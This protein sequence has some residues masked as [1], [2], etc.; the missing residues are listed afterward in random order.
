ME[1]N[2]IREHIRLKELIA[3][4][5]K[6]KKFLLYFTGIFT[7]LIFIYSLICPREYE[8]Y[9]SIMPPEKSNTPG[10]SSMLSS[11]A[12]GAL[13]LANIDQSAK[14]VLYTEMLKSRQVASYIAEKLNLKEHRLFKKM[15]RDDMLYEILSLMDVSNNRSGIIYVNV[16]VKTP[17]F[18]NK[19]EKDETAKLASDIAN[20]AYIALDSINRSISSTKAF[21]KKEFIERV[22]LEK[23]LE[24]DSIDRELE[25][26]Q[27]ENKVLAI[28]KQT[29]AIVTNAIT[30]G[31]EL[32]K[33]EIEL[34]IMLQEY[35]TTSPT[36]RIQKEKVANLKN[37]YNRIQSGGLTS[38]DEFSIPLQNIPNII[39]EYTNLLR[40]QK[41]LEQVNIYLE[42]QKY[43]EAIQAQNDVSII[44]QLDYAEP[45]IEPVSPRV[46]TTTIFGFL[47]SVILGFAIVILKLIRKNN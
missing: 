32:A 42:T 15:N 5:L 3:L 29:Q 36:I 8:A 43:Q 25:K 11:F 46:M 35:E 21:Q 47:L 9:T 2:I 12:G 39:R 19:K 38:N 45:A 7:I 16:A 10:I 14:T 23:Q 6:Q 18:A 40:Q 37:Q 26:Y 24:L 13:S 33:A 31:S 41:I 4:F 27:S 44:E 30:I 17:Y 1:E 22:L 34:N 20:Y 28:D